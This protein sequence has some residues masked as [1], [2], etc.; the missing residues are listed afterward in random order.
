MLLLKIL[1]LT[2]RQCIQKYLADWKQYFFRNKKKAK[3]G[4]HPNGYPQPR[5][6]AAFPPIRIR[7]D[8][9]YRYTSNTDTD[10]CC[11]LLVANF[12]MCFTPAK[13]ANIKS[14]FKI[15]FKT[16]VL[17]TSLDPES[18]FELGIRI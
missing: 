9:K 16:A 8:I 15:I 3:I 4:V 14:F 1:L 18:R 17:I 6:R 13:S 11:L 2:R 12:K 7:E 5:D 10:P